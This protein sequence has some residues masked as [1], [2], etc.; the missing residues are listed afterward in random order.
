MLVGLSIGSMN[1][2]SNNTV[3]LTLAGSETVHTYVRPMT[4]V[5]P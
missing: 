2:D 4:K 3:L 5:L 1:E